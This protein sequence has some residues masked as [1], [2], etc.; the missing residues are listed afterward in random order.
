MTHHQRRIAE[1]KEKARSKGRTKTTT[2]PTRKTRTTTTTRTR[3]TQ[4]TTALH[5]SNARAEEDV[6]MEEKY[7]EEKG[8][9][10]KMEERKEMRRTE[11]GDAKGNEE[12]KKTRIDR[13]RFTKNLILRPLMFCMGLPHHA[14]HPS[15]FIENRLL[16]V[17]MLLSLSKASLVHRWLSLGADSNNLASNMKCY[18]S[19]NASCI[20][21]ALHHPA[22]RES[23]AKHLA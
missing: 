15:V 5:A 22:E 23:I 3:T 8:G 18:F 6:N 9:E 17:N 12:E 20:V 10:T 11:K 19:R 13:S 16:D 14:H 2:R 21:L 7:N 4:I 1:E